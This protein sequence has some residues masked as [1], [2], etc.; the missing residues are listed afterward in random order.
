MITE[1][2]RGQ[3][4]LGWVFWNAAER[5]AR[6]FWRLLGFALLFVLCT[7]VFGAVFGLAAMLAAGGRLDLEATPFL[8]A[9]AAAA[10]L[11]CLL[12]VWLAGRFLDRRNFADFGLQ[13]GR[14]WWAD[15][16]FGLALGALLMSAIFLAEYAAGWVRIDGTFQASQ[17]GG[18]FFLAILAPAFLY[19]CV[20]IYE[21]LLAR[22]YLLRNLAEGFGAAAL[23]SRSALVLAWVLSSALFGLG[24]AGN[25]N[26][27]LVSTL[28]LMLAGLFLGLGYVL[29]GELAIPIGIH[30]T[31]N[32]FQGNVFGFPVSGTSVR[33]AT[34]IAI[35]Q[36]GPELWTGGMFGPEAG[37][38]GLLALLAGSILIMAWVRRTRGAAALRNELANYSAAR[39][40][41]PAT[42]HV[43]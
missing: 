42:E 22:G 29:T 27:T 10:L 37:L 25:P 23:G 43:R 39:R 18:S 14:H 34:F 19:L 33:Q 3:G 41:E 35:E 1:R 36:R 28:L 2:S 20:G 32:F 5:R 16:A 4:P 8:L 9:G 38:V 12:S 7:L 11:S 26:A 24:H 31:W 40:G 15:L 6:A 13:L 21:E 17:G 30:I